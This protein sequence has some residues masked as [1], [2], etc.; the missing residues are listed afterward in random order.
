MIVVF[1]DEV[2]STGEVACWFPRVFGRRI[3]FPS[4]AVRVFLGAFVVTVVD[5]GGDFVLFFFLIFELWN[6]W[7]TIVFARWEFRIVVWMVWSKKR[8]VEDWVDLKVVWKFELVIIDSM[9]GFDDLEWTD[10]ERGELVLNCILGVD[11]F[12]A[13]KNFLSNFEFGR[14]C[15]FGVIPFGVMFAG[16]SSNL[17]GG[18]P[19]VLKVLNKCFGLR[20]IDDWKSVEEC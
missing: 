14:W 4:N 16:G 13:E 5:N 17:V 9:V 10:V 15:V 1:L 6:W 2:F 19:I 3:S 20:N 7:W 8:D 18:F 11:V 12:A